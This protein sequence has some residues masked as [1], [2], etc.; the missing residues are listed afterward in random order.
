M[1]F[2][3]KQSKWLYQ[4][5]KFGGEAVTCAPSQTEVYKIVMPLII[6]WNY[7]L[8]NFVNDPLYIKT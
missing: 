4:N 6:W 2:S 8:Y 5:V 3:L 7:W 1:T